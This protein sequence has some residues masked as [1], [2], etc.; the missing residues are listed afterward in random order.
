MADNLLSKVAVRAVRLAAMAQ[1]GPLAGAAFFGGGALAA[2]V[3]AESDLA[4][5]GADVFTELVGGTAAE[6]LG[7]A[8]AGFRAD[9]NGDLERSLHEAARLA[10]D[11]LRA[12]APAG[13][14]GWF[15]AWQDHIHRTAPENL[16][17][18]SVSPDLEHLESEDAEFRAHW[19]GRME[20]LLV[21]WRD[22]E[23][24]NY[25]QL[26]LR[27]NT[28]LPEELGAYLRARL[29]E[30]MERAHDHVLRDENYRRS[31]IAQ[32]QRIYSGF[33]QRFDELKQLL[34]RQQR[35]VPTAPWTIPPPTRHYQDRPHL[36]AA[37]DAALAAPGAVTALSALHGFGGIGKTQIARAYAAQRRD[38]YAAAGVWLNAENEGSLIAELAAL[39]AR[40]GLDAR[41]PDQ[42]ALALQV[43][44]R[45]GQLSPRL[46]ILDNAPTAEAVRPW[47]ARLQTAPTPGH[48]LLTSRSETWDGVAEA[49]SVTQW[50]EEES[51]RFL[52]ARTGQ[53]DRASAAAL[54]RELD[55]LALALEHA[56]AY[57][58]QGDGLPLARYLSRWR[59]RLAETP[60]GTDYPRSV[61]A[62]LGL[63]L[64]RLRDEESPAAY[65]LLCLFAY[66][67]PDRI[68]RR[69]LLEAGAAKL[70]ERVRAALAEHDR[71]TEVIEAL[72]RY[73]LLRREREEG[74]VAGY[75]VHRVV[76]QVM[77]GRMRDDAER[78]QWLVRA[79]DVLSRAFPFDCDEP[80]HWAASAA[81]LPHTQA[82]WT[83]AGE[84]VTEID[85]ADRL[86]NQASLYLQLRG[87]YAEAK[88][89]LHSALAL[90]MRQFGPDHS[91]VAIRR[92]NL[93]II[94]RNL[95]EHAAAREQI[96]LALASDLKQFGPDHPNV[97]ISRSNLANIL[98]NLG[99][100]AA[101]RE[102]IQL[103]L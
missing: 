10:L 98:R 29:P 18:Q 79:C 50:S 96:Q 24:S 61:A 12:G 27:E 44:E 65:E 14:D 38:R 13:Y 48:L 69:E 52:L 34:L 92:S 2:K 23:A 86:L 41:Q 95:G 37:I 90:A 59:A 77:R 81:L 94:L 7:C 39:A 51:V 5:A 85:S 16:F 97:A 80:P 9:H 45:L 71:W 1:L 4:K 19:W 57:M 76:Q 82:V 42:Q 93:A 15:T 74:V 89:F 102:Q 26:H 100:H 31:W 25:Q 103:A 88:E 21:R 35:P 58:R 63:S 36:I 60:G 56:A 99:E 49:V 8:V 40:L 47:V 83:E 20:P 30:A 72:A 70:P 46:V 43:I 54:A 66:L 64:D 101:A 3:L 33:F 73:S 6:L 17:T 53:A 11:S 91:E 62:T 28:R 87:L 68:P 55:G 75:Y 32:Q 22:A 67:A 78:W 84:R